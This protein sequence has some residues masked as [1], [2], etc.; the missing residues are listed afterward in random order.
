MLLLLYLLE[1]KVW[2]MY[3]EVHTQNSDKFREMV[4]YNKLYVLFF[5]F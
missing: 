4:V 2:Q 1:L 5:D 3:N